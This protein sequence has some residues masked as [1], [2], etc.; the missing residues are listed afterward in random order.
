MRPENSPQFIAAVHLLGRCGASSFRVGYSDPDDGDPT[1]WYAMV[2]FPP[3]AAG[4]APAAAG[5][6]M[7]PLDAV[8]HLCEQLIDGGECSHCH[9]TTAF[10]ADLSDTGILQMAGC[11]LYQFDPELATFRRSCEGETPT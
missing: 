7:D 9:R 1:V 6:G 5:G 4:K 11:C 3:G 8:F 2:T 10:V